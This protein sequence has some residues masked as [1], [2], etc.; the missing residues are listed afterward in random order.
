[1][2][3][4]FG[5]IGRSFLTFLRDLSNLYYLLLETVI[6]SVVVLTDHKKRRQAGLLA[7]IVGK[8]TEVW[9]ASEYGDKI[10]LTL[11]IYREM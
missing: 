7:H 11:S 6:Q 5:Y 9:V 8:V 4:I 1:M 10:E 3:K 2:K